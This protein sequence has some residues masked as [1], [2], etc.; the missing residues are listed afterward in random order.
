[1]T[2]P[3]H[4]KLDVWHKG[5]YPFLAISVA[6]FVAYVAFSN[7]DK[8]R[9]LDDKQKQLGILQAEMQLMNERQKTAEKKYVAEMQQ[10]KEQQKI[11]ETKHLQQTKLAEEQAHK[12]R[13]EL[14]RNGG[15][16][17]GSINSSTDQD[18][19]LRMMVCFE[20]MCLSIEQSES[21]L[22]G[23]AKA[24]ELWQKARNEAKATF[25]YGT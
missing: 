11:A 13:V 7:T 8:Q 18:A 23:K 5:F 4:T 2:Q 17:A 24:K 1:M 10:M 6:A 12:M 25:S 20:L 15:T 21:R 9:Q 16:L 22:L 19:G 14:C 3:A